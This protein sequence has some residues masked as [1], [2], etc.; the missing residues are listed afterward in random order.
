MGKKSA[1]SKDEQLIGEE[2]FEGESTKKLSSPKKAT[3]L[4]K[5]INWSAIGF[6]LL[7]IIGPIATAVI[8]A[9]DYFYPEAAQ[10]NRLRAALV[11]CYTT[12]NPEKLG[13]IDNL[14][15]KHAK[16]DHVLRAR[17]REKYENFPEC[18]I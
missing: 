1:A 18:H 8:F 4:K 3:Q 17:L 15:K 16:R 2:V 6:L 13:E 11:R 12:A 14:V 5:G 10:E 7:F 9:A